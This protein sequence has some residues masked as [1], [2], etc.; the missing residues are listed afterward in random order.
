M[1]L[2]RE[3]SH[4]I[5]SVLVGVCDAHESERDFFIYAQTT[6][7]THEWR[8]GGNLGMGGKFWRGAGA[9]YVSTYPEA[10]TEERKAIIKEANRRLDKLHIKYTR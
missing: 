6:S 4:A 2:S 8:F 5:Y 1:F 7:Y 9:W 10:M 3:A